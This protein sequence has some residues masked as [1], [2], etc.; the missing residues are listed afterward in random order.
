MQIGQQ[1]NPYG[2]FLWQ[3]TP[4]QLA[5]YTGI[6][7][8]A[9]G[10]YSYLLRCA[11]EDAECFPD[12]TTIAEAVGMSRCRVTRLIAELEEDGFIIRIRRRGRTHYKF[13]YHP[14]FAGECA[15]ANIGADT[16]DSANTHTSA[17]S[18]TCADTHIG[19]D[20]NT[21]DVRI[22]TCDVRPRT[23]DVRI[24]TSIN[25]L[26]N[27]EEIKEEAAMDCTDSGGGVLSDLLFQVRPGRSSPEYQTQIEYWRE[28]FSDEEITEAVQAALT[29]RATIR[30]DPL[31][32]VSARLR[33]RRK[34]A[35]AQDGK[36]SNEPA[37]RLGL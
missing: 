3:P 7:W 31:K 12:Q 1:F 15:P 19:A 30:V 2:Q 20:S 35:Q 9:K 26:R 25:V 14:C 23:S 29:N 21:D 13:L 6:G 17:D 33:E 10:V 8:S 18:N 22:S 4:E 36:H 24:S 27:K 34:E 37:T 16:H 32:W 11:G 28:D 5:A